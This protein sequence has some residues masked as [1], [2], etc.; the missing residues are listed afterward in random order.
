MDGKLYCDQ[1]SKPQTYDGSGLCSWRACAET[2]SCDGRQIVRAAD[3][4]DELEKIKTAETKRI[5]DRCPSCGSQSLFIGSDGYLTCSVVGCKN[6]CVGNAVAKLIDAD[7]TPRKQLAD[8]KATLDKEGDRDRWH[9][10][11][12]D[13]AAYVSTVLIRKRDMVTNTVVK[14]REFQQDVLTF[15]RAFVM[16]L[17]MV[18]S[19]STHAEKAARLRG[20]MELVESAARKIREKQF[21]E[22]ETWSYSMSDDVFRCDYPVRHFIDKAREA[23]ARAKALEEEIEHIKNPNAKPKAEEQES[24]PF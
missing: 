6:P 2:G 3:I 12:P 11:V 1:C 19:A 8:I 4:H 23:E 16:T 5:M 9:S 21:R 20:L 17:E 15:M 13:I 24:P 7:Q 14:S 18:A 22:T 10:C